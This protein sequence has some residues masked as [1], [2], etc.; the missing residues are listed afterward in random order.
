ME[1]SKPGPLCK[2]CLRPIEYDVNS[3]FWIHKG[4]E[5]ID[6]V[7]GLYCSPEMWNNKSIRKYASSI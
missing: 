4:Y 5:K 1:I 3:G 6:G 2:W 7:N